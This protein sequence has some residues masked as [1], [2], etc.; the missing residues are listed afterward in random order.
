MRSLASAGR[1]DT[2]RS[3]G[4][5]ARAEDEPAGPAPS[6][7]MSDDRAEPGRDRA[8]RDGSRDRHAPHREQ[9][10]EMELQADAEHQQDDADLG[11]L[12][13]ERTVRDESRCVR[14]D[15]RAGQEVTDDCRESDAA[16]DV[17]EQERGGQTSGDGE[18]QIRRMHCTDLTGGPSGQCGARALTTA[19][20]CYTK[21]AKPLCRSHRPSRAERSRID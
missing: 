16:G 2:Q 20:G 15:Q 5:I 19:D 4:S 12:F 11:Q 6:E 18:N 3:S 17:P 21:P 9:L 1:A 10:L 7:R 14:P 8:L 13:G